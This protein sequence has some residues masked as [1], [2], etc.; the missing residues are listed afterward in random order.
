[1]ARVCIFGGT[2][3]P[4]H[5][6]HLAMARAARDQHALDL[7]LWTPAGH[8]P[9][10]PLAGGAT[11]HERL[12]MVE[13]AIAGEA[14]FA[15]SP[16]DIARSGPSYAI[17]THALLAAQYPLA[18]WFWLMGED[19]LAD[20]GNWYCACELIGRCHWLVAPRPGDRTDLDRSIEQLQQHFGG[21]FSVLREFY[22]DISST[23]VREQI[24][25]AQNIEALVP[26]MVA[27][28][29]YKNKLYGDPPRL[30]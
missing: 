17:E 3:N 5:R 1:M 22:S 13:L 23:R 9:H 14:G 16:V 28:F 4:V 12:T 24:A 27:A 21:N 15:V 10:K 8:P 26:E 25:T 7:M 29:I 11:T 2:F 20:L 6:G 18:E 30:N 19:S